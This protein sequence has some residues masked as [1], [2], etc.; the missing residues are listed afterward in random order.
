MKDHLPLPFAV[1]LALA[2]AFLAKAAKPLSAI[3]FAL[4][5]RLM[6][7]APRAGTAAAASG[8]DTKAQEGKATRQGEATGQMM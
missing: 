2:A 4:T 7:G 1:A 5:S 3:F 6:T 8:I